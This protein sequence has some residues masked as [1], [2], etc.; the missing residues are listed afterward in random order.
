ML[1]NP[2]NRA[3]A[4]VGGVVSEDA[5]FRP[6][7]RAVRNG[8]SRGDLPAAVF[9]PVFRNKWNLS[10]KM[11]AVRR[12]RDAFRENKNVKDPIEIQALVNKAK[13]DLEIIRRQYS[14]LDN[15]GIEQMSK[16]TAPGKS[17]SGLSII[18]QEVIALLTTGVGIR[19][20]PVGGEE[21]MKG[22]YT[23]KRHTQ[24]PV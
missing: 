21:H 1:R 11:Y 18:A 17:L 15:R 13:R 8:A 24:C 12:I 14:F 6:R 4:G 3:W 10:K 5:G 19:T 20:S 9:E 16:C 22:K 23:E 7:P 2:G